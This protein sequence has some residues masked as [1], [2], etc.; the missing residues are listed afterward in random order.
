MRTMGI[1][2]I[3]RNY[4]L[5]YEVFIGAN[6]ALSRDF[7]A[8][9]SQVTQADLD[10][11]GEAYFARPQSVVVEGIHGRISDEL[12]NLLHMLK[13]EQTSLDSYH[14][15][16]GE[17]YRRITSKS[18]TSADILRNAITILT[19]AT[20]RKKQQGETTANKI[21][22]RSQE[23]DKVR[24]ELDEYKRIANTDSLTRLA[25]RRAFDERLALVYSAVQDGRPRALILL[26]IDH[27]KRI[28]DSYGHP[29]GDKILATVASVLRANVRR[30]SFI[31]RTGGEEFAIIIEGIGADEVLC[32]CERIRLSLETTQF[33]NSKAGYNYG[34]ITISLGYC[35]ASQAQGDSDLY[36]RAD[37]AL[38]RA[39][40]EGRNR[41]CAFEEDHDIEATKNWMLYRR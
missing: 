33:K 28:N 21:T 32:L 5:F 3:P 13:Q 20:D 36:G 37:I 10:A 18:N 19:E 38:Y 1:A 31:A 6:P 24:Q 27:F 35:M 11:L 22:R 9:G 7:A 23:M 29:V 40:Q 14:R 2:P 39:K 17:T 34:P 16:L 4:E 15:V 8:L 30:D 12:E 26:D 25:N 41:T